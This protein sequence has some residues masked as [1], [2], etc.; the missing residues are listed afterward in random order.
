MS[1]FS[2]RPGQAPY[3]LDLEDSAH[4]WNVHQIRHR[5]PHP[6]E[7]HEWVLENLEAAN[8]VADGDREVFLRL[9]DQWV[10][11]KVLADPTIVRVAYW[12]CYR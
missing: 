9:F 11:Q 8:D 12:K 4:E 6:A 10:T 7:Y 3:D 2:T 1:T 5:G